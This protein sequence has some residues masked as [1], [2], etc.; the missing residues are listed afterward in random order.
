MLR[1]CSD[2]AACCGN[3]VCCSVVAVT[4]IVVGARWTLVISSC[5]SN[6]VSLRRCTWNRGGGCSCRSSVSPVA[7][8]LQLGFSLCQ[9]HLEFACLLACAACWDKVLLRSVSRAPRWFVQGGLWSWQEAEDDEEGQSD[10]S[11][12]AAREKASPHNANAATSPQLL[13]FVTC[14]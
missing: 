8:L 14:S 1:W 4:V 3:H 12:R 13:N 7:P 11:A 6:L 2:V 5:V 9:W 10:A